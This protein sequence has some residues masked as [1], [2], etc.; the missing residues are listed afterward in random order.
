[1]RA[2]T[3]E[4]EL[5]DDNDERKRIFAWSMRSESVERVSALL[6]CTQS[7]DG[8]PVGVDGLDQQP[9]LFNCSNGTLDLLTGELRDP[10]QD[11]LLTTASP[12]EYPEGEASCPKW[13][14]FLNRIFDGND[15]L[16]DY[17]QQL[18]GLSLVGSVHEHILPILWGGG[19][20]G[21]S[22]LIETWMRVLGTDYSMKAPQD[23]LMA[24]S[25]K[26]HPTE[27]ADLFG[28]RF[29][30]VVESGQGRRLDEARVKE[31]SGGD[32]V[33]ARRVR[34]DFFEFSPSHTAFMATNH[35]PV[36]RG[37]DDGIWRRHLAAAAH[38]AV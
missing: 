24:S 20:N 13:F 26:S 19:A 10:S 21:K 5:E 17:I 15:E 33:R 12:T 1:V 16:I 25:Q 34:Q 35:R 32:R 6:K 14:G 3:R 36:V 38:G 7:E 23:L 2:I 18:L 37:T 30:A 28:K 4:I 29:V 8:I 27:L 11:D 22:V 31:L 9:W